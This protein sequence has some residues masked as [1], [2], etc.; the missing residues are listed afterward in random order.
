MKNDNLITQLF[1]SLKHNIPCKSGQYLPILQKGLV[2]GSLECV[3]QNTLK[4]QSVIKNFAYWRKR[5]QR[6]FPSQFKVTLAGTQKWS[7]RQLMDQKDRI[8]FI[9][10]DIQG[11]RVGHIGLYRFDSIN[12][13]IEIDN[14]IRGKKARK[15]IM[16]SAL[17]ALI[18]WVRDNTKIRFLTLRVFSDNEKAIRLYKRCQ[19]VVKRQIPL[20][21]RQDAHTLWWDEKGEK[22]E[23]PKRYFVCMEL[24]L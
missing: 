24:I 3:T 11:L 6:W 5:N 9:I 1:F 4:D 20:Y 21:K 15:G 17:H 18:D 23:K 8:L 10:V 12:N 13:A 19:F 14:V 7:Q 16:T 2:I 22:D